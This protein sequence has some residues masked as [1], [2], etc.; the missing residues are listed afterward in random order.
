MIVS[1]TGYAAAS[2][3]TPHGSLSVEL[4]SVNGRFL[5]IQFRLPEDLRTLEPQLREMITA[6][7]SRG[8]VDCRVATAAAA[9]KLPRLELNPALLAALAE[10]NRRVQATV[11]GA[12]ALSVGEVLNWPGM[13]GDEVTAGEDLR[14]AGLALAKKA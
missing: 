1:M 8:K 9:G 13:L 10:V 4:K 2:A 12:A 5:E 11:P 14:Q 3:E 7:V 6:R